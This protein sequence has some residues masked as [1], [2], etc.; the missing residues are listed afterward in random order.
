MESKNTSLRGIVYFLLICLFIRTS[1]A[2]KSLFSVDSHHG[3]ITRA[4]SIEGTTLTDPV[5]ISEK[6]Y[7]NGPTGVAVSEELDLMFMCYE[8][9]DIVTVFRCRTLLKVADVDTNVSNLAGIA[10]DDDKDKIYI[11]KRNTNDLYVYTWNETTKDLDL[12]WT[13]CIAGFTE[14]RYGY[15]P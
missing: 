14:Q 3:P 11:I 8:G 5:T 1:R 4:Y 13:T 7:G 9:D 10:T 15:C 2:G 6:L 12:V